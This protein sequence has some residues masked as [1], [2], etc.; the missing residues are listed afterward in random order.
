MWLDQVHGTDVVRADPG[1]SDVQTAD[2]L[3]TDDPRVVCGVLTADCLPVVLC[4]RDGS[5]VAALHAGWRGLVGGVIEAGLRAMAVEA[6]DVLAWLGPAIG[7][8]AFEVGP[9]VREAFLRA[10]NAT[11]QLET[12]TCFTASERRPGHYYGDL[13]ALAELRL[14]AAGVR[15]ISAENAC[16]YSDPERFF[17]YRR[18][19]S[20][21]RMATFVV[22][23]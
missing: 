14:R 17:S 6:G 5:R 20:T 21:G 9:E 13:R 8:A 10:A 7:P 16:T 15:E 1:G 18:D 23:L 3:W 2:G 22:R 19:A 12:V 11:H 4:A